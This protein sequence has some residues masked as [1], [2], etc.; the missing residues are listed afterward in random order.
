MGM[1]E[2][3]TSNSAHYEALARGL[4]HNRGELVALRARLAANRETHPLLDMAGCTGD[5]EESMRRV[6]REFPR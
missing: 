4:A 2:L 6:W 1:P 3:V 5:S